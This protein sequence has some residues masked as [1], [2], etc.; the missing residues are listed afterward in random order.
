[1]TMQ[2]SIV[3]CGGMGLR[4]LYGYIELRKHSDLFRLAAVCD[5][6]V[7]TAQ[8]LVAE[9][10]AATGE[11]PAIYTDFN[12]M[13]ERERNLDA[14]DI[15]TDTRMHHGF[16]MAAFDAGIHVMTE[17]PMGLTVRACQLMHKKA[18]A[19]G[20]IL[21]IAENYRRDPMNR[22]AKAIIDEGV[23]G[24]PHFLIKVGVG[25][26]SA[27]MHDT[28]WRALKSRAGSIIIEQGVHDADL[29]LYFMGDVESVYAETD[30][31][32]KIR[33]RAGIARTLQPFYAHRVEDQFAGE[34]VV[35]INQVDS[36]FAV[37]RFKSG[38]IGHYAISN[39]SH[40]Y[41][42]GIDTLHGSLGVMIMPSSRSGRGPE[43][44]IEGC[45]KPLLGDELLELVPDWELD[46]ITALFF[47]NRHRLSSYQMPFSD[48]DSRI[49]A[50]EYREFAAAIESSCKPEV[51]GE[52]GMKALGLTYAFLES[53]LCG[54]PVRMDDL[55]NGTISSYQDEINQEFKI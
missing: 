50:I 26:G 32:T 33:R 44:R 21:S 37:I 1:M 27:L 10:Y 39:A 55:I 19:A 9:L 5:V 47:D 35:D 52:A 53:G 46:D 25:G 29:M 3:G 20:R 28:G 40:G 49:I 16:A 45:D 42:N 12:E 38:V 48:V 6:H 18:I 36:A 41:A 8:H 30:I 24:I 4:H 7:E 34:D 43:L 11:E 22:L 31:F 2:L 23:I 51:D 54:N 15:V 17:K 13:L 14:L